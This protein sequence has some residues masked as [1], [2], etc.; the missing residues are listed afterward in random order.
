MVAWWTRVCVFHLFECQVQRKDRL[1]DGNTITLSEDSDIDNGIWK[2]DI[3]VLLSLL[4]NGR[5][6]IGS[7]H[8]PKDTIVTY[9]KGNITHEVRLQNSPYFCVIKCARAVKQK[10]WSEAKKGKRDCGGTQKCGLS[11]L[12]TLYRTLYTFVRIT[13]FSLLREISI[14]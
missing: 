13:R 9:R 12:H 4:C 2:S 10:I 14:G 3:L 8:P 5:K 11:V 6:Y 7:P 1:N